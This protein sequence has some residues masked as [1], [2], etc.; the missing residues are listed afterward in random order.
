MQAHTGRLRLNATHFSQLTHLL[1]SN[2][3]CL[4]CSTDIPLSPKAL[5]TQSIQPNLGLPLHLF[6]STSEIISSL[7]IHSSFILSTCPSHL[8]IHWSTLTDNCLST[9]TLLLI[10]SFLTLFHNVNPHILLRHGRGLL[11]KMSFFKFSISKAKIT[12]HNY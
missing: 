11:K 4:P 1:P 7:A 12:T 8:N 2:A 3:F 6:P 9:C 10:S 5:F